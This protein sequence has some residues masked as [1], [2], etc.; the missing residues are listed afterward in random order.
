MRISDEDKQAVR[1]N[2]LTDLVLIEPEESFEAIAAIRQKDVAYYRDELD[3]QTLEKAKAVLALEVVKEANNEL[4]AMYD[5]MKAET[6]RWRNETLKTRVKLAQIEE[7]VREL[8][9]E[10]EL[11]HEGSRSRN[12]RRFVWNDEDTEALRQAEG[13]EE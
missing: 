2:M 4:K 6:K 10:T 13:I 8:M 7:A 11:E 1:K 3:K 5:A 9:D 12:L